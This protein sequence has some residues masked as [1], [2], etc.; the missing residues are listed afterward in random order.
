M[1]IRL[2]LICL[3][4]TASALGIVA[5]RLSLYSLTLCFR[6]KIQRK[7]RPLVALAKWGN[8]PA[9][10][11]PNYY[12]QLSYHIFFLLLWQKALGFVQI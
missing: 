7:A 6:K 10:R 12:C 3:E 1:F 4:V 11:R 9:G 2:S 5:V 8:L